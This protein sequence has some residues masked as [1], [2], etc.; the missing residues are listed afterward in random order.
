MFTKV[1][2]E[3]RVVVVRF[4][5]DD[6]MLKELQ[7]AVEELGIWWEEGLPYDVRTSPAPHKAE[8]RF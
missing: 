2:T 4:E 6:D 8:R 5:P 7:K 1:G 3:R